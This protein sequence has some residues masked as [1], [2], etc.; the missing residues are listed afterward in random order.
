MP[1]VDHVAI[2]SAPTAFPWLPA[3]EQGAKVKPSGLSLTHSYTTNTYPLDEADWVY[4]ELVFAAYQIHPATVAELAALG[5]VGGENAKRWTIEGP[6]YHRPGDP[7]V[8]SNCTMVL[9]IAHSLTSSPGDDWKPYTPGRYR[10]RSVKAR[11]R[12]TRP[13]T[14]YEFRITRMALRAKRIAPQQRPRVTYT[15]DVL[16]E[17]KSLIVAH[18][19]RVAAGGSLHIESDAH[20]RVL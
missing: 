5:P 8:G 7:G 14:S 18:N 19:Y 10:L 4:L 17:G 9:E 12:L 15:E 13:H 16:P 6:L 2:E 11:V 3:S 1:L 20:L